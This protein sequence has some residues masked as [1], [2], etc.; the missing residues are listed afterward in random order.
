MN[1]MGAYLSGVESVRT[2]CDLVGDYRHFQGNFC[3]PSSG[4]KIRWGRSFRPKG[5]KVSPFVIDWNK[6][7]TNI[8][9][10]SEY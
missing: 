2:P 9:T 4:Q 8:K 1:D 6:T 3:F 5:I 7:V 10:N